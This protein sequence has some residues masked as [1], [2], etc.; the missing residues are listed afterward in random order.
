[1]ADKLVSSSRRAAASTRVLIRQPFFAQIQLLGGKTRDLPAELAKARQQLGHA[2]PTDKLPLPP[3]Y[4]RT[5][6]ILEDWAADPWEIHNLA[7][8]PA[9]AATLRQLRSRLEDWME[10][11][12]DHGRMPEPEACY[13]SDMAVYHGRKANPEVQKNIALMKQWAAEGK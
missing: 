9:H 10:Q 4:P 12:N 2:T 7:A 11:S 6:A 13:D 5:P 1:M 8:G 3:Y